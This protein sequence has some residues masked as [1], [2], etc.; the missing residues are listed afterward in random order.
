MNIKSAAIATLLGIITLPLLA[1]TP[2]SGLRVYAEFWDP[3]RIDGESL[4]TLIN[5]PTLLSDTMTNAWNGFRTWYLRQV[6]VTLHQANYLH[7]VD[8]Q[9]PSGISLYSRSKNFQRPPD[10]T[11]PAQVALT[12]QPQGPDAFSA[13]FHVAGAGIGVCSTT[14]DSLGRYADPCADFTLDLDVTFNAA[15]SDVPGH[16]LKVTRVVVM[17]SNF[18]ITDPNLPV[19]V[20]QVV[21]AINV[22]FGGTDFQQLLAKLVDSQTYD[23]TPLVQGPVD[24]LNAD[25]A[26]VEQNA[27]ARINHALAPAGASLPQ[28]MHIALWEQNTSASQ[29]LAVL[30][31]PPTGGVV[32]NTS[33][34]TGQLNGVMTFE[35][36]VQ[37]PPSSCASYDGS[38]QIQARA[39]IGPRPILSI[40]ANGKPTYGTAPTQGLNVLFTGSAVQG[41]QCSYSLSHLALAMPNLIDFDKASG[42][43]AARTSLQRTLEITPDAWGNPLIVGPGGVV[44][45]A[46]APPTSQL[47]GKAKTAVVK[48]PGRTES[49]STSAASRWASG[50]APLKQATTGSGLNLLAS[51]DSLASQVSGVASAVPDATAAA[52][53]AIA[54]QRVPVPTFLVG[55]P[56][57]SSTPVVSRVASSMQSHSAPSWNTLPKQQTTNQGLP[58]VPVQ[59]SLVLASSR[60]QSPATATPLPAPGMA[61]TGLPH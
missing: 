1:A 42:N 34:Q 56:V 10:L 18:A 61:G 21:N 27:L 12:L 16:L 9:I 8:S 29:I 53:S 24:A 15:I 38:Q 37:V 45:A 58:T 36:S 11:L 3:A 4:S 46:G 22:F 32:L 35:S 59:T 39:Q 48:V 60:A 14:P 31:A 33:Q 49:A 57:V 44:L 5:R 40:D 7:S 23:L 30:L 47:V 6:P 19:E 43:G 2:P 50:E 52:P 28:L 25:V 26:V 54:S 13:T 17:P 20:A 41:R 51:L 55:S